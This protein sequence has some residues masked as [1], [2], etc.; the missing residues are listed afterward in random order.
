MPICD[1]CKKECPYPPGGVD[2]WNR[3]GHCPYKALEAKK[4]EPRKAKKRIGQQKQTKKNPK[5]G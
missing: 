2:L 4:G 3:R 1:G 5:L